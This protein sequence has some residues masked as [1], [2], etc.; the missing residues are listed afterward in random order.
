MKVLW[1]LLALCGA[2]QAQADWSRAARGDDVTVLVR[3][4]RPGTLWVMHNL[5][6]PDAR[7]TMSVRTL[8]EFDCRGRRFKVLSSSH[9]SEHA[10]G[11]RVLTT[12]G[13][14]EWS[15]IPPDTLIEAAS[16]GVCPP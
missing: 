7:G 9:H 13:E 5:D 11:G 8:T 15:P 6:R 10:G 2:A 4:A 16:R 12:G 14:R 1:L 3:Y